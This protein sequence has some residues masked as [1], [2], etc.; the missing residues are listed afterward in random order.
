[1]KGE[2][3]CPMSPY[4]TTRQPPLSSE[5]LNLHASGWCPVLARGGRG[6]N[7]RGGMWR[8]YGRGRGLGRGCRL[9]LGHLARPGDG[10]ASRV[11]L[12]PGARAVANTTVT[13]V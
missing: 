2:V 5:D 1:M 12:P 4:P 8:T 10:G 6:G 13:V 7:G 3:P 11:C 9:G